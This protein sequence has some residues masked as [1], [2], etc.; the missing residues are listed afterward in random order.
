M[1]GGGSPV[2]AG[3]QPGEGAANKPVSITVK[4][5]S[6]NGDASAIVAS[7]QI[8]AAPTPVATPTVMP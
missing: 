5:D 1:R 3:G 6:P 2:P 8:L 4:I 7:G